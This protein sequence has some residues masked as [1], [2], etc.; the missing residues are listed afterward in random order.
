MIAGFAVGGQGTTGSEPLLFR[1]SGPA[2]IPFGETDTLPDPQLQ[3]L[4]GSAVLGTNNGW[5]GSATIADT[6]ASVNAFAWTDS[7]SHDAALLDALPAGPYTA[8]VA[9][10]SGDTGLALAEVYDATPANTY[11]QASRRL[12]NISARVQIGTGGNILIAGFVIGGSTSRTVLIRASGP[13]LVPFGV[14]GALPDPQ[15][16]LYSGPKLLLANSGWGGKTEIVNTAA[17]VGAFPWTNPSSNDSALV[18]TL[19]P[20]AYTA[21]VSGASGDTGVAL[22]EVY[23][24]P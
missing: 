8:Q 13:A 18:V 2:L 10:E 24:V 19:P 1:A 9:G 14:T 20:G 5:G 22:A 23:E 16:L 11:T 21:Q 15:L 17:S 3:L 7:S 12:V 6:A 4:S